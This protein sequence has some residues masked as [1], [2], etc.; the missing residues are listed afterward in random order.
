LP[1]DD[2]SRSNADRAGSGAS[3]RFV[4][5]ED[6]V[7]AARQFGRYAA[8]VRGGAWREAELARRELHR[9]GFVIALTSAR[10]ARGSGR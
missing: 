6:D 7:E 3:S 2:G 4:A 10:H 8:A 1:E 9:L 5:H